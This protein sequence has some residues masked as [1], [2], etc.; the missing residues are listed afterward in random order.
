[1]AG[2]SDMEK[3]QDMYRINHRVS[4]LADEGQPDR[5]V[6]EI[7]TEIMHVTDEEG[8]P[9]GDVVVGQLESR[10][11]HI[12]EWMSDDSPYV[13]E[14]LFDLESDD[15]Y[16]FFPRLFE[17]DA[18]DPFWD[19]S[20]RKV[21]CG[22]ENRYSLFDVLLLHRMTI[23]EPH[24]GKLL[25]LQAI[26]ETVRTF[27]RTSTLTVLKAFPLNP[28]DDDAEAE[29]ASSQLQR[30]YGR[31][32]FKRIGKEGLMVCRPG[33]LTEIRASRA[34]KKRPHTRK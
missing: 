6:T 5:Y 28:P 27:A 34:G 33:A 32:G 11:F 13:L 24:R 22:E 20:F 23:E 19:V 18:D 10:L 9:I 7:D 25:G 8:D 17:P 31:I 21:I 14:A 3:V 15:I 29:R 4:V 30:Y 16:W 26:R 12:S 2:G 1:M